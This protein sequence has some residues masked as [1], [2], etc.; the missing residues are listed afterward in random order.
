[1]KPPRFEYL[2]PLTLDE[3]LTALA[4]PE[5]DTVVLAGGQSL[6]PM[7]NLRIVMP[8][9]VLDVN[10]LPGLDDVAIDADRVRIGALARLAALERHDGLTAAIPVLREGLRYVAHPQIRNRSTLGGTLCHADPTAEVPVICL[11]LGAT[12]TLASASGR[13]EVP[14]DGF[15]RSV[16]VTEKHQDELLIGAELPV[17]PEFEFRF[18]E[19]ARRSHGDFPYVSMCV[20]VRLVGDQVAEARLAA[21][22]V[23]ERPIRLTAAEETL[24]GRSLDEDLGEV[25]D[26]AC[27]ETTPPT[28]IHG[29]A[30]FRRGL[31]RTLLGR[32]LMSIDQRMV[33]A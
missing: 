9:T 32:A 20:G 28:D 2:A 29:S 22:G 17:R 30:E 4:N 18:G 8:S 15:F 31:L 10:R 1:M 25:L 26:A 11:A 19:I 33:L 5:A 24:V 6:M 27:E 23:A 21:G 14:A 16:L 3:A 12:F 13:R 7:L